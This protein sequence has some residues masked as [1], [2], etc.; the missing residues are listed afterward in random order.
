M[1]LIISPNRPGL[2]HVGNFD[3]FPTGSCVE[4]SLCEVALMTTDTLQQNPGY[5]DGQSIFMLDAEGTLLPEQIERLV[6]D[7]HAHPD[8]LRQVATEGQ[9]LTRTLYA[10]ERQIGTRQDILRKA[11]S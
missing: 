6:R 1:D 4:A 9:R 7:L 2:L 11:V 5:V 3:G 10:P 8:R